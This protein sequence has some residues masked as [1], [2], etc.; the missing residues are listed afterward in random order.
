MALFQPYASSPA[1]FSRTQ[2]QVRKIRSRD[3]DVESIMS[4]E[5]EKDFDT[6]CHALCDDAKRNNNNHGTFEPIAEEREAEATSPSCPPPAAP[7][8]KLPG[9][10][11]AS[12]AAPQN[13]SPPVQVH[14]RSASR[15]SS[16]SSLPYFA[17][18][19]PQP[20]PVPSPPPPFSVAEALARRSPSPLQEAASESGSDTVADEISSS[21]SSGDVECVS[22]GV[23][24]LDLRREL[25]ESSSRGRGRFSPEKRSQVYDWTLQSGDAEEPPNELGPSHDPTCARMASPDYQPTPPPSP[26]L[27]DMPEGPPA[28][29]KPLDPYEIGAERPFEPVGRRT[30]WKALKTPFMRKLTSQKG[31]AIYDRNGDLY[32]SS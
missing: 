26:S 27:F 8:P 13:P 5:S 1:S 22:Q 7:L 30:K 3:S 15:S 4:T 23:F 31:A 25:E 10:R 6:L 14:I 21:T 28:I 29:L 2:Q 24:D 17:S 11:E 18:P 12:S 16:R 20:P 19:Q 9:R 32:A